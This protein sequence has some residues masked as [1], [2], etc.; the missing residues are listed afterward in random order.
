MVVEEVETLLGDQRRGRRRR[1]TAPSTC[2]SSGRAG[3]RRACRRRCRAPRG[4]GRRTTAVMY[5]EIGSVR[6]A[7][8]RVRRRRSPAPGSGRCRRPSSA[9]ARSPRRGTAPS[10]RAARR[11]RRPGGRP[12]SYWCRGRPRRPRGRRSGAAPRRCGC[13]RSRRPRAARSRRPGRPAAIRGSSNTASG[14]SVP[15][16]EGDL[17]ELA[18]PGRRRWRRPA[19]RSGS[20]SSSPSG[21]CVVLPSGQVEVHVV[22]V[23]GQQR[24]RSRAS[25]RVR[26]SPGTAHRC[27]RTVGMTESYP[28][29]GPSGTA[30]RR[31]S[32]VTLR[33]VGHRSVQETIRA[34]PQTP[35]DFW[36]DPL[37][38]WAWMTSRWMLEVEKVRTSRSAGT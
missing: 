10:G 8:H 18:P 25:S 32:R 27:H 35:V 14:S 7:P 34:D 22:P 26:F 3:S 20:G 36:F 31:C 19:R 15:P 17:A 38:P 28:V 30:T 23:D 21:R 5:V 6:E 11:W 37:C 9:P 24:R 2:G 1:S 33:G 13:R 4:T 16:V 29:C 12:G